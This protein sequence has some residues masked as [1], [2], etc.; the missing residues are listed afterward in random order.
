MSFVYTSQEFTYPF[1]SKFSSK[2]LE[3]QKKNRRYFLDDLQPLSLMADNVQWPS[4]SY[5]ST[6]ISVLVECY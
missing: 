5:Y 1:A 3:K 4:Q 6:R 2:T